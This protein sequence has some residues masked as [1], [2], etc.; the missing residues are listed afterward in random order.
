MQMSNTQ[1]GCL[2]MCMVHCREILWKISWFN[3]MFSFS[4]HQFHVRY[5]NLIHWQ[6][7]ATLLHRGT[8]RWHPQSLQSSCGGPG[9]VDQVIVIIIIII[10]MSI[11]TAPRLS[12]TLSAMQSSSIAA[13]IHLHKSH[14]HT[15]T[16]TPRTQSCSVVKL[17]QGSF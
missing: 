14:T 13:K 15:H 1:P 10:V 17:K 11:C 8:S 9:L 4:C 6:N 3:P 16:H 2:W 7:A 12:G 5:I